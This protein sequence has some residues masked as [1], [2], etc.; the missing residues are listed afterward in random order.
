[1]TYSL[2]VAATARVFL[3][4]LGELSLADVFLWPDK[5]ILALGNDA[6]SSGPSP[7][8]DLLLQYHAEVIPRD[9]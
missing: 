6:S 5:D 1:M 9:I 2:G 8:Y 3:K 4:T 7:E